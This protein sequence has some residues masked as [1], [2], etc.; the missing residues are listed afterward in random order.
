MRIAARPF[1][2]S[3]AFC[4]METSEI[5]SSFALLISTATLIHTWLRARKEDK[6]IKEL[7][8][9]RKKEELRQ[10]KSEAPF[11]VPEELMEGHTSPAGQAMVQLRL[12]NKGRSCRNIKVEYEGNYFWLQTDHAENGESINIGYDKKMFQDGHRM[13]LKLGFETIDGV[14]GEHIYEIGI[15]IV[16]FKRIEPK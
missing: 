13:N 10:E 7:E 15:G 11:F 9:F 8:A 16:H 6:R 2:D 4:K 5:I 12:R 3:S 14:T 1:C